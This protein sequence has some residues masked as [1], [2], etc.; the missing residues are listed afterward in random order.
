M[1][2]DYLSFPKDIQIFAKSFVPMKQ[3][4]ESECFKDALSDPAWFH[5]TLFL[6]AAHRALLMGSEDS[7]PVECFQHKGEAIRIINERLGDPARRVIDG[8]I[9]AIACLAAFEVSPCPPFT[10]L[11][12]HALQ[13]AKEWH[14]TFK[15]DIKWHSK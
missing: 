4:W 8:T 13:G 10:C 15:I 12:S 7:L 14:L 3:T 2:A 11:T 1:Q 6:S 9:A 5:S